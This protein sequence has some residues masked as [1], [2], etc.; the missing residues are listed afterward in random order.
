MRL[1]AM[2]PCTILLHWLNTVYTCANIRLEYKRRIKEN[3]QVLCV[4]NQTAQIYVYSGLAAIL[5]QA[6]VVIS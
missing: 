3:H 2:T 6:D 1:V 5:T 4:V